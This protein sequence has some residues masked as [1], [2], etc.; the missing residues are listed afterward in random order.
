MQSI[1]DDVE[2]VDQHDGL[3]EIGAAI[4]PHPPGHALVTL[5]IQV[6]H[7]VFAWTYEPAGV[8]LEVADAFDFPAVDASPLPF[9]AVGVLDEGGGDGEFFSAS[10][11]SA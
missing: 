6:D 3:V 4:R 5:T 1:A 8:F 11:S 9:V 7:R 2:R 10:L